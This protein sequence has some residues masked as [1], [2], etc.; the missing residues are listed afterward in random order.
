ML[1]TSGLRSKFAA[2]DATRLPRVTWHPRSTARVVRII[3]K[4]QLASLVRWIDQPARARNA[5][6]RLQR[7]G[8]RFP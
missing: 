8:V 7:S 4:S 6:T 3:S 5:A 1:D 2:S